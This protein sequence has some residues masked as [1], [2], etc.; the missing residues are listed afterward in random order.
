MVRG[1]RTIRN[2]CEEQNNIF[3][4]VS[5]DKHKFPYFRY[6]TTVTVSGYYNL[7]NSLFET[8]N[9]STKPTVLT[10]YMNS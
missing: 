8:A 6:I 7:S 2:V 3:N 1:H 10:K 5:P 9:I 4:D